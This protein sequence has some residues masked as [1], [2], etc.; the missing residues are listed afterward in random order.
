MNKEFDLSSCII[1]ETEEQKKAVQLV[2]PQ[3]VNDT[4]N[5]RITPEQKKALEQLAKLHKM[6]VS[7]VVRQL[8]EQ[9]IELVNS[10]K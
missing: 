3:T 8:V 7:E 10:Q 5:V 9:G 6:S 4:L 2:L 1:Q